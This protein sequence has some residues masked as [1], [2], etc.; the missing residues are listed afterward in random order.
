MSSKSVSNRGCR[1]EKEAYARI[2]ALEREISVMKN[3]EH[4]HIV[5]YL[6]TESK[7]AEGMVAARDDHGE[8]G[9]LSHKQPSKAYCTPC[10]R[11]LG[12]C[13]WRISV[14]NAQAIWCFR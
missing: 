6:G 14:K 11:F 10:L 2:K 12:V 7:D 5:R 9:D 4:P 8:N 3:L 13:A 1:G